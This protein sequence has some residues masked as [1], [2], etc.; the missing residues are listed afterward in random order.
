ML[1][2]V[3]LTLALAVTFM[4]VVAIAGDGEEH[5]HPVNLRDG[6]RDVSRF[7]LAGITG[8]SFA[9][10]TAT[11]SPSATGPLFTSGG[12]AGFAFEMLDRAWRLEAEGRARDPIADT[13]VLDSDLSTSTLTGSGGW[14]AMVN[15]WRDYDVTE[16]LTA[17]AGGGIGGG[18]YQFS[19]DQQ[20][21]V[22]DVTVT[23]A[24]TVGGFAWQVGGGLAFALTDRITLDLG[25]RFFEL[26]S[27][28]ATAEV[29][30]SGLPV[31][32][33]TA[34]FN[35]GFSASELFF[36]IRIYEPF[37]RWR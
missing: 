23:G 10:L 37:R 17:Y 20:Y 8:A 18:G 3:A 5:L 14:S 7:Y 11:E 22:Q 24:N 27:G 28:S 13:A 2:P 19:V 21:P 15:L 32:D 16:R 30:Q 26:A 12:A 25:Y 4:H 6:E 29:A 9:T 31:P 35:A 33:S 1:R 36:A 34:T